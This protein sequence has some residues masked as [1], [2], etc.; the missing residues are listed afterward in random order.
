MSLP[1]VYR[2]VEFSVNY[3]R[4]RR[5]STTPSTVSRED[6][7]EFHE[8]TAKRPICG[9]ATSYSGAIFTQAVEAGRKVWVCK[10]RIYVHDSIVACLA[11]PA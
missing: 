9:G 11:D 6:E 10:H 7:L 5:M 8:L 3:S 4:R 2:W 1:I